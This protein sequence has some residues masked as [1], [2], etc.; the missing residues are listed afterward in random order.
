MNTQQFNEKENTKKLREVITLYDE[1]IWTERN[2]FR[3]CSFKNAG[4]AGYAEA[5]GTVLSGQ[6]GK[7]S[8]SYFRTVIL[9]S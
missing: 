9:V 3:E 8:S 2:R 4:V 1:C 5:F 6:A 7:H